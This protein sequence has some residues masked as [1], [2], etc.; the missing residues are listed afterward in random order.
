VP[1]DALTVAEVVTA[2]NR[3]TARWAGTCGDG[4]VVMSGA[5]AWPV[6]ALLGSAASGRGRQELETP[7]HLAAAV[8]AAAPF[9]GSV[10]FLN[11]VI[12]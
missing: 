11:D 5:G 2:A 3:L 8:F 6:L 12:A 10:K 7:G 9:A 1:Y 4:S